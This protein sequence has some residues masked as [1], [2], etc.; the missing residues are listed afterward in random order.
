[1]VI[2]PT[3]AEAF[4]YKRMNW[5]DLPAQSPAPANATS[6]IADAVFEE[7]QASDVLSGGRRVL[8]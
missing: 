7:R 2:K 5:V 8:Q 6:D 1:M 3:L 4:D